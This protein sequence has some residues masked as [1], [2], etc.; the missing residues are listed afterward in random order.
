MTIKSEEWHL[1]AQVSSI[2][3]IVHGVETCLTRL[4]D[5]CIMLATT[6]MSCFAGMDV[7]YEVATA[8]SSDVEGL[9]GNDF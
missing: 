4:K 1:T 8:E 2:R 9:I 5:C 3:R 7:M 6:F